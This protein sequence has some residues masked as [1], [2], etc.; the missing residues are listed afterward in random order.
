MP[1]LRP[2]IV[3]ADAR[4]FRGKL[5]PPPKLGWRTAA[6][7]AGLVVA[8]GLGCCAVAAP[9]TGTS[10]EPPIVVRPLQRSVIKQLNA[11]RRL[12]GLLPLRVAV[13][14]AAAAR[15]HSLEMARLGYF[16]HTS[17]G[18]ESFA[19]RIARFYRMGKRRHWAAGENIY[20]SSGEPDASSAV[21]AWLQSPEHRAILLSRDWRE[22]GIGA[23]FASAG[24]GIYGGAPVT[25][26]T[27]DFGARG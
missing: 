13:G 7:V 8:L 22:I 4:Q 25:I 16:S 5:A 21:V 20:W 14:L 15:E 23:V 10:A 19:R 11:V 24:P 9:A 6:I 2:Q 17:A 26:V 1:D 12:H 27:A 3:A 18:G